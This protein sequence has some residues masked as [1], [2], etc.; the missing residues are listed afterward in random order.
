MRPRNFSSACATLSILRMGNIQPSVLIILLSL[1]HLPCDNF[2]LNV[3]P[4]VVK[5]VLY[6]S[7]DLVMGTES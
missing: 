3:S 1:K 2:N 7:H 6:I 4:Y 5:T